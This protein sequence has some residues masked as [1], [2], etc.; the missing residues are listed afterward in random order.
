M[1]SATMLLLSKELRSL[2]REPMVIAMIVLPFIIYSSMSPFYGSMAK[3]VTEATKLKGVRVAFATCHPGAVEKALLSLI[4][5]SVPNATVVETCEPLRLL[6]QGYTIVAFLNATTRPPKMVFYVKGSLSQLMKTMALPA[7]LGS[8]VEHA[9]Q[10]RVNMTTEAYIVVNHRLWSYHDLSA[11][12]NVSTML[13]YAMLFILFPAASLGAALIGS[14]REER[15]LEVL[16][17]LPVHRRSIAV[18]K[19]AAA[20]VAAVLAAA[21]AIA[22]FYVMMSSL[23][24]AASTGAGGGAPQRLG[25]AILR[26]YGYQGLS[27]YAAAVAAEALIAVTLAMLIGLFAS[28]MRGA[29]SAAV[30]TVL[31]ALAPSLLILA[32]VPQTPLLEAMPYTATLYAALYPLTGPGPAAASLAAQLAWALV[33]LLLLTKALESEIAITGPEAAKRLL[34]RLRRR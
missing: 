21:S 29:Q 30:V 31:P 33:A 4:A 6:D 8:I 32:G 17:T 14:E 23:G 12:F 5:S 24:G 16:F 34:R 3:Q 15:T 1:A 28:T 22:G 2:L 9:G 25:E 11:V 19:A 7:T 20:L 27:L 10:K 18:S 26:Y 13:S